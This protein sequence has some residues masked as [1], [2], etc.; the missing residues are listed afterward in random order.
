MK[1]ILLFMFVMSAG[2]TLSAQTADEIIQ[3]Y[4]ENT[5]GIEK[6]KALKTSKMEGK[7]AMQGMEF[8][9]TVTNK[10]P[11]K[12]RVDVNVQ[13]MS[14]VQAYDG[15]DAWWINPF[16]GGTDAQPMPDEMAESV[17]DQEFQ[18]PFL[19]YAA[20]GH[21]VEYDGTTEVEGAKAHILKLTKKN[22]TVEYHYFDAEHFVIIMSKSQIKNGEAKGQFTE[23]YMSDYQEVDG[24][25]FPFFMESK[26]DGQSVQKITVTSIKLNEEYKDD[27]FAM[28]KKK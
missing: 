7:M 15:T 26:F 1:R 2:M 20:K 8:P 13:G 9:G 14:I 28:P 16:A 4:F 23:T 12:M 22:G 11:N 27:M 5:G 19:D 10:M 17:T 25:M 24:L 3:K 6:W 21:K 18:S